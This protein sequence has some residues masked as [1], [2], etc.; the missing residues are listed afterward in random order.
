[1]ESFLKEMEDKEL[2][3]LYQND[4]HLAFEELYSRHKGKIY[5]YLSKR[6]YNSNEVDDI[7]QRVL[8]KLHKSRKLY[9]PNFDVLPWFYTITKSELL[10]F[11]KRKNVNTELFDEKNHYLLVD[12]KD[13]SFD[14]ENEKLL[15]ENEKEAIRLRYLNE[16]E[17]LEISKVLNTSESN[18]RKLISRGLKK[19]KTKYLRRGL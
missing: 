19:L 6:I 17:F 18:A 9:N 11:F 3:V 14:L 8:L 12:S 16:S 1:M 5:S 7:Y 15:S 13:N 2:M 4:N 10:D